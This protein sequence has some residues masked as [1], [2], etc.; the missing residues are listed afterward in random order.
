MYKYKIDKTYDKIQLEINIE[1]VPIND[2]GVGEVLSISLESYYKLN[3]AKNRITDINSNQWDEVKKITNPYEFIH[4]FNSKK[5]TIDSR[6]IALYRP[7][8]RS[9]FKMIEICSSFL[10][11]FENPARK[12]NEEIFLNI[13]DDLS[14]KGAR[15]A[16]ALA[17]EREGLKPSQQDLEN[18][19]RKIIISGHI[20]EGPGGFIE[21]IRYIRKQNNHNDDLAFGMTLIKYDKSD[22]KKINVLGWHKS[23][24][25]LFNNP[26]VRILN[27]EDGTGNIYKIENINFFNNAIRNASPTGADIL[28]G[29]GGF[30]FS[31]DY[32]YQEQLSC[33]LIFSQ[34]LCALKCQKKNGTFICKFFDLN[35]YFTTEM[36]YLLY[37]TYDT[38]YI[39]KPFTSRIANSEKYIV[40]TNF[41]GIDNELLDN[42]FNV[43]DKWNTYEDKT[44]NYIFKTIPSDFI[45]KIKEINIEIIDSQIKSINNTIDIIKTNKIITDKK[46]YDAT[47]KLQIQKATQ[48]CKTYNIPYN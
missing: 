24:R 7:L 2:K 4:T 31:I 8:S 46:W 30:D 26:E 33:K 48:W 43:L 34:I 10:Q 25:F 3:R 42:L 23:N 5:K 6:S 39:Y 36:L 28:T 17:R 38:L 44:I 12:N 15:G 40:C 22:Y 45:D 37:L 27:G 20:A 1:T 14:I 18:P 9:F 16:E 11:D 35:L 19:A 29:D 47:V 21:A 13:K 32:N 41:N